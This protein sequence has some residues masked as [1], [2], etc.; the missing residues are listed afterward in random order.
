VQQLNVRI[1][2][3]EAAALDFFASQTEGI[4]TKQGLVRLLI[5]Q[6]QASGWDPLTSAPSIQTMG[7]PAARRASNTLTSSSKNTSN[8]SLSMS[9]PA[10]L[11]SE[12]DLIEEF[13]RLKKGSKGATAWKLLMTELGKL[14]SKHGS[15]VVREQLTLAIN[16][17]W[18]GIT[19]KNYEQ[20]SAPK[21]NAPRQQE[22][23]PAQPRRGVPNPNAWVPP[24]AEELG[25][26]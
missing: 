4:I 26:L 18:Q 3:E 22:Q 17:K 8:N 21:G 5:R 24:T 25:L 7:E 19:L 12:R 2:D 1:T 13:W 10:E 6:A 23:G 11:E 14:R 16:G 9:I 15:S 20:F